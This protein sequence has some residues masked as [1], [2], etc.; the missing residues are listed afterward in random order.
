[1][2]ETGSIA[3]ICTTGIQQDLLESFFGR[4]RSKGGDNTNPT[5]EQFI[6]NFRRI[7]INKELTSSTLSNCVDKLE[8]LHI[9]SNQKC[10]IKSDLNFIMHINEPDSENRQNSEDEREEEQNSEEFA[11]E[12]NQEEQINSNAS[13]AETLGIANLAGL[14]EASL[15]RNK[16]NSC[17]ECA[18][19]FE[20][21]DKIDANIFIR[22]K[23]NVLPCKSTYEICNIGRTVMS[24]YFN[25]VHISHFDYEKLSNMIKNEIIPEHFYIET[26]FD[27]CVDHKSFI[28]DTVIEE[29]IKTRCTAKARIA[30]MQQQKSFVRSAK[31]HD[32]HFAGL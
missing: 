11:L 25:S 1:M 6:G 19:V 14:I 10:Y 16:K 30:T 22:N 7:L 4:M 31:I 5:Q 13:I 3:K 21:N 2:V 18:T 23:K 29:M 24:R 26:N 28:I 17:D 27:H 20:L 12:N 32:I 9:S 15:Q 8:I